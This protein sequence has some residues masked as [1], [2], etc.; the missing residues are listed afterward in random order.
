MHIIYILVRAAVILILGSKPCRWRDE[1]GTFEG[2]GTHH[3]Y[4]VLIYGMGISFV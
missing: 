4:V 1:S 3:P 2:A